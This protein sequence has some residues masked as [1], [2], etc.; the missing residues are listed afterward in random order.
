MFETPTKCL[1]TTR[2][3][4]RCFC[5]F[6]VKAN[7]RKKPQNY[8]WHLKML[9]GEGH[10]FTNQPFLASIFGFPGVQHSWW[11]LKALPLPARNDKG[12][13]ENH[14]WW[15]D[16]ISTWSIHHQDTWLC[17]EYQCQHPPRPAKIVVPATKPRFQWGETNPVSH[18]AFMPFPKAD[19][20]GGER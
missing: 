13:V 1:S 16:M 7:P 6:K 11:I 5:C 19:S 12:S 9:L 20:S 10:A 4:W 15:D 2:H 18:Y 8:T 3:V 17:Y 14:A